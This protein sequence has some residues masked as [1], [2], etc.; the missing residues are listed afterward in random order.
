MAERQIEH[1]K[2]CL[3]LLCL[4]PVLL[5]NQPIYFRDGPYDTA[6]KYGT[7]SIRYGTLHFR[8]RRGAASL[9]H[10]NRAATTR[11]NVCEQTLYPV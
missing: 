11:S 5:L 1:R 10:R 3:V 7:E 4:V 6:P 8:D 9:R 2:S